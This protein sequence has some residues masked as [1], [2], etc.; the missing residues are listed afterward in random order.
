LKLEVISGSY[1][2]DKDNVN[3]M[4]SFLIIKIGDTHFRTKTDEGAGK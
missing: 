2:I 1:I 3:K 4:N